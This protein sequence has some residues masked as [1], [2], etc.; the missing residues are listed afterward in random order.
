MQPKYLLRDYEGNLVQTDIPQIRFKEIM[1]DIS[2]PGSH[3]F[4]TM[5]NVGIDKTELKVV[6][7]HSMSASGFPRTNRISSS[8]FRMGELS[9][10]LREPSPH[11]ADQIN[12]ID[13]QIQDLNEKIKLLRTQRRSLLTRAFTRGK[14]VSMTAFSEEHEWGLT[15]P[16]EE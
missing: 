7:D 5:Q 15:I 11:Y 4:R 3:G 16:V 6:T 1:K 2:V 9:L 13:H 10:A 14:I 12:E 8:W